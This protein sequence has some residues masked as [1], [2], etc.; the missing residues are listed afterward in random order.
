MNS[1]L[2][3]NTR[4]LSHWY[5]FHI[6]QQRIP[7][8]FYYTVHTLDASVK[9]RGHSKWPPCHPNLHKKA[10][11]KEKT[12]QYNIL[13]SKWFWLIYLNAVCHPHI[14]T[15]LLCCMNPT[16]CRSIHK[17]ASICP[18]MQRR[19]RLASIHSDI[20]W[21]RTATTSH[22]LSNFQHLQINCIYC[23]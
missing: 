4:T 14:S 1:W 3:H 2:N 21:A 8:Y 20:T 10:T 9:G 13:M 22:D 6:A 12:V 17:A 16:I 11:V 23:T 15:K 5:P 19:F 18:V 7:M